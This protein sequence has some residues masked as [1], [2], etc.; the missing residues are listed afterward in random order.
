M[1]QWHSFSHFGVLKAGWSPV[2]SSILIM[3]SAIMVS[4]GLSDEVD[5]LSVIVAG[6]DEIA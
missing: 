3:L 4:S 2:R 5:R 6:G 1:W